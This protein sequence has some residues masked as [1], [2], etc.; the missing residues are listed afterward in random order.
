M[1][2]MIKITL[3]DGSTREVAMGTTPAQIAADIGPGLAKAAL[4]AKID[5]EL[6]D[7][8]R[9]LTE[10]TELALV[11]SRDEEDALEVDQI[12]FLAELAVVAPGRFLYP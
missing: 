1:T 2:E 7:I 9:P 4:A 8:M 3:P 12:H 5:G 10:D 6:R 11:T